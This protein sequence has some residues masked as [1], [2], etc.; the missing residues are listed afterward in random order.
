MTK[1]TT[2]KFRTHIGN[3][4]IKS[5]TESANSAYYVFTADHEARVSNTILTPIDKERNVY[6]DAYRNMIFG[7]RLTSDDMRHMVRNIPW[8]TGTVFD[9]YDDNNDAILDANFFTVV[10]ESSFYHVYKCLDNNSNAVSTSQPDFSHIVGSNTALYQTADGYRWKY[11]Y[12]IASDEYDKFA[13]A[14]YIPVYSNTT[15][16]TAAVFGA[17]DVIKIENGGKNYGNYTAGVFAGSDVRVSGNSILYKISNTNLS[18]TNGYYTGCLIYL[19]SGTG[20]G[21]H[22]NITDYFTNST[23]SYILVNNSFSTSP[24][25]GTTYEIHPRVNIVGD[26]SQTTNAI[27]RGLVNALST[28]SIYR[29]EMLERGAGYSYIT[30]DVIANSVVGIIAAAELRPIYSPSSGHGYNPN[31]E[32][33]SKHIA[34]GV[35]FSASEGNTIPV[36]NSFEKIGILKDPRFANVEFVYVNRNG[37]FT[38][39]EKVYKINPVRLNSNA[40]INTTSQIISCNTGDFVNQFS[41]GEQIYLKSSNNLAHMLTT[42]STIT[43][44]THMDIA[45]NGI[46]ACND[47]IIYQ[48][49]ASATAYILS[50]VNSTS[51]FTSNV[52][53]IFE[54]GDIYV[55]NTSGAKAEISSITRNSV[56]KGFD[57]FVQLHKYIGEVTSG[58]FTEDEKIFQ[59]ATLESSTANASFHSVSIEG[60][61][62][63][64]YTSNQV[65]IF[66][67]ATPIEGAT[68]G[69]TAIATSNFRP[70]L[71]FGSG[72]V[73][74]LENIDSVERANNKS[75][76]LKLLFNFGT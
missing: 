53:G 24:K 8:A 67:T 35:N 57:T 70:E 9:M 55:G 2:S 19:N 74:S 17:V 33:G 37:T 47:V 42:I 46:F 34:I 60:A 14:S 3:Q 1:L 13:T 68:S 29:V 73:L 4:L 7:K 38:N 20:L 59:G 50:T 56:S 72:K 6:I 66:A 11:M 45:T 41:L 27:A 15:V 10:D 76:T 65:G 21:Q 36:E 40:T 26:G 52:E 64:F 32:L 58:T 39:G 16:E 22:K 71:V 48:A 31:E 69:A 54:T 30:A 23:G 12:S 75:E 63:T 28:N 43:N 25:N 51:M 18:Q 5:I 61:V 49:N 62:A 44:A